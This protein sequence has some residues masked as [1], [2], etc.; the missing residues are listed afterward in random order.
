MAAPFL[1]P[2]AVQHLARTQREAG[3]GEHLARPGRAQPR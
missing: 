1:A 3:L 2:L